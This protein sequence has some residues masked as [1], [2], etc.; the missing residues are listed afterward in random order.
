MTY[1][2]PKFGHDPVAEALWTWSLESGW[3]D[4]AG[5][6]EDIGWY[7]LFHVHHGEG[8][9]L[10]SG[11]YAYMPGGHSYI[12]VEDD[13]GFVGYER[14]RLQS[15]ESI[16]AWGQILIAEDKFHDEEEL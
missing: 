2:S 15:A 11:S 8:V 6:V 4:Q 16:T 7:A 1:W 3:D 5:T 10:A 13:Q 12:L 9:E 14:Y